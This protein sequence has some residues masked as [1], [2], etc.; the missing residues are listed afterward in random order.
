MWGISV[1]YRSLVAILIATA[2][3]GPVRAQIYGQGNQQR[4]AIQDQAQPPGRAP[5]PKEAPPKP[6]QFQSGMRAYAQ[7]D[8]RSAFRI[9]QPMA[10]RGDGAAQH[11]LGRMYARG[12]G[13]QRDLAEAYKWFTLAGLSGRRESEQARKAIV[14]AMT[15][16][17][18][19]E[20]L[21]RA[22]EWRQRHR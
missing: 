4:G 20:G 18:Q 16:V 17:Q 8:F 15:P 2:I 12:E 21:R 9:W 10:E 22:Q 19:A 6:D 14:R 11:N 1:I 13:V 7:N 3:V 5:A